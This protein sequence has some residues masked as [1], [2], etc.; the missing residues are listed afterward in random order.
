M[1]QSRTS[2]TGGYAKGRERRDRLVDATMK[3]V[4]RNGSRGTT[5]A[6]IAAEAEVSQAAVM[7]HFATKDDLLKAAL[8]KR[9]ELESPDFEDVTIG[10][11]VFDL[12]AGAVHQWGARPDAVGMHTV[13]V[14][15]NVGVDGPLRP[16]LRARYERTVDQLAGILASGQADGRIRPDVDPQ[17]KAIEVL[18]FLNGLETAWLLNPEAPVAQ[19]ATQWAAH[20]KL[21]LASGGRIGHAGTGNQEM[22]SPIRR[23][24]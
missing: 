5:L 18:A 8:D 20:Q 16:R 13:L 7:Y 22:T 11:G 9:D 12:I 23:S 24:Q 19:A 21:S 14:A 10:L 17:L 15:E 3:L 4:A 1:A 6:Q 2:P